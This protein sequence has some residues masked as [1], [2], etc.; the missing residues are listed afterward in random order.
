MKKVCKDK[1]FLEAAFV[2]FL[3]VTRRFFPAPRPVSE[4]NG[5]LSGKDNPMEVASTRDG[6][7]RRA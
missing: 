5:G 3:P 4:W 2:F 7:Y 6:M 1:V